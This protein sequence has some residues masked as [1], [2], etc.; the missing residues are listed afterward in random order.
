LRAG[1]SGNKAFPTVEAAAAD[2][3]P[4]AVSQQKPAPRISGRTNTGAATNS[5]TQPAVETALRPAEASVDA[6]PRR[7]GDERLL[8]PLVA[9]KQGHDAFEAGDFNR[10]I[11]DGTRA[12][13]MLDDPAAGVGSTELLDAVNH[14]LLEATAAKSREE[15]RVYTSS[16]VGITP[17][18]ALSRQLPSAPPAGVPPRLVGR[19]EMLINQKGAVDFVK[20]HTPLNRYHE[21]MIVSAAKAWRYTPALKSGKPVRY[22]L[23][24]VINLPGSD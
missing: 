21:R 20:L 4:K 15:E 1:R 13:K 10:A 12:L 23:Q 2:E 5:L 7:S 17:P 14:L 3:R 24:I 19:L 8:G 16:D 18:A 9:Y 6:I 22:S 11:A